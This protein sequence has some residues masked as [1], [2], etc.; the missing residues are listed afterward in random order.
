MTSNQN[1]S[2]DCIFAF[3]R[4]VMAHS[5]VLKRH[6][7]FSNGVSLAGAIDSGINDMNMK[8]RYDITDDWHLA[9]MFLIVYF[10]V[11]VGLVGVFPH[12]VSIWSDPCVRA[13]VPL[14]NW[15]LP[16]SRENYRIRGDPVLHLSQ[17]RGHLNWRTG[18][19][20]LLGGNLGC[21]LL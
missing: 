1:S 8:Y 20:A 7:F 18:L 13:C 11:E 3:K 19:P 14:M 4:L 10:A 17:A 15:R 5:F 12:S 21:W 16:P 6:I 2:R 9:Y